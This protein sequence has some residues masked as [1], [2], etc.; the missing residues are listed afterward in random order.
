MLVPM[1]TPAVPMRAPWSVLAIIAVF[2]VSCETETTGPS[3]N[4]TIDFKTDSGYTFWNDTVAELDTLLVGVKLV[5]GSDP[6][7]HFEISVAYDGGEPTMTDS[8]RLTTEEF[9]FD[10]TIVTRDT[11]GSERWTFK[12]TEND[13]DILHRSLT[14]TVQ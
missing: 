10:K 2:V 14:F 5:M 13:G 7:H 3:T 1:K 9:E 4:P 11:T 8:V 6:M 12:V